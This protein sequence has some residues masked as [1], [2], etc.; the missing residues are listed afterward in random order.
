MNDVTFLTWSAV[1]PEPN[2]FHEFLL[3]GNG[4]ELGSQYRRFGATNIFQVVKHSDNRLAVVGRVASMGTFLRV[5]DRHGA[6]LIDQTWFEMP[7]LGAR[8]TFHDNGE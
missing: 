6:I 7:L 3:D 1:E 8:V 4:N 2:N 5:R